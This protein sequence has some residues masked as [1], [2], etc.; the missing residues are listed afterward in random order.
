MNMQ[1]DDGLVENYKN[2]V[3]AVILTAANDYRSAK[4][5][6]ARRAEKLKMCRTND[7]WERESSD[8]RSATRDVYMLERFFNSSEWFG[9][10]N[11]D[12]KY[13]LDELRREFE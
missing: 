10:V 7:S 12:G 1:Y 8:L 9:L 3:N 2:L 5:N 11:V 4:R 6:Q 13:I